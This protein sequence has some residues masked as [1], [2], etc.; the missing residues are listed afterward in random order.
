MGGGGNRITGVELDPLFAAADSG[1]PLISK[2]LAV[3]KLRARYLALEREI[4][5]TWLDWNKLGPVAT[6]LHAMIDADV[7]ADTRKLESYASFQKGLLDD[8][9][10]S[11]FGPGGGGTIGLKSFAD[12]RRAYLLKT[13]P[14]VPKAG[15]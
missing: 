10:G 3:P 15:Q 12:Q 9:P 13:I 6:R 7:K 4:A 14:A 1:K 2:L 5:D 11:G 8:I